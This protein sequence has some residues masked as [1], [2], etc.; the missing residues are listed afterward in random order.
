[1]E[2]ALRV[3]DF[4]ILGLAQQDHTGTSQASVAL[5]LVRQ[6]C[7]A[8]RNRSPETLLTLPVGG[9]CTLTVSVGIV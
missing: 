4:S 6:A 8:E 5:L 2:K 3:I 9:A 1:M 7:R